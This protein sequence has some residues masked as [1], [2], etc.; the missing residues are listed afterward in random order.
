MK[1]MDRKQRARSD[2][3]SSLIEMMIAIIVLTVGL[4]G[5]MAVASVSINGNTRDRRDSTSTAVAE[6]VAGQ[7]SAIPI[8]G[9]VSSVTI[10]DCA[11]NSSTVNTSGTT[12]G[13]GANL[14]SA[15]VV[16]YTQSFSS[17]TSGYAM[18]YTICGV[19]SG[20]RTTY[21]VRWNIT[22]LASSKEEY[23]VVGAQFANAS[24]RNGQVYTPAV[25]IRTV[26]GNDGN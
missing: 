6:M 18:R 7:I 8:N 21:D 23:V 17:V 5:S 26:V 20:V 24:S 11:G 19:S 9:G 2:K 15:G 10:T 3:G 13:A 12:T 1:S 14:T 25:N 16:D 22:T 4:I